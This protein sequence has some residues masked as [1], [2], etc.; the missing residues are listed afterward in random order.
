MSPCPPLGTYKI[1]HAAFPSPKTGGKFKSL[2]FKDVKVVKGV[3]KTLDSEATRVVKS[4]P[5]WTPGK[6]RGKAVN[7][8]FTLPIKFRIS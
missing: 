5:K 7:A 2:L 3:H 6:Q 4:M 1:L 8:R